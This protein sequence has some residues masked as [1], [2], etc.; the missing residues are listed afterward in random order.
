M[1]EASHSIL[2]LHKLHADVHTTETP[3]GDA[4]YCFIAIPTNS[5]MT[6]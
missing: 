2:V 6:L 5:G 3:G 1:H 4:V